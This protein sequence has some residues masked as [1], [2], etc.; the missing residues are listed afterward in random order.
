MV[1]TISEQD[2]VLL[3]VPTKGRGYVQPILYI[4]TS[5]NLR[6]EM[7]GLP[8]SNYYRHT[9]IPFQC[10]FQG[11]AY[12]TLGEFLPAGS[13]KNV[14]DPCISDGWTYTSCCTFVYSVPF[15]TLCPCKSVVAGSSV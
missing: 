1:Q 7:S 5:V 15:D 14:L 10:H 9:F 12:Q 13:S 11:V 6:L 2:T 4:H 3:H 8:I